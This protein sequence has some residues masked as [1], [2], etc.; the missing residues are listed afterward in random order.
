M[1][2]TATC[3]TIFDAAGAHG[4]FRTRT[5]R[6]TPG[7]FPSV[8]CAIL[9]RSRGRGVRAGDG[10]D[11]AS[12]PAPHD[13]GD[14]HRGGEAVACEFAQESAVAAGEGPEVLCGRRP[15]DHVQGGRREGADA[16]RERGGTRA[17]AH[18]VGHERSRAG[19]RLESARAGRDTTQ[20][21]DHVALFGATVLL[22]SVLTSAI[23]TTK[24]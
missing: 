23:V 9:G 2:L 8:G 12:E 1:L 14:H 3:R 18:P 20:R 4:P 7:I 24:L 17:A 19:P 16:L 21:T 10:D 15:G 11:P 6:C 22:T 13:R 5:A